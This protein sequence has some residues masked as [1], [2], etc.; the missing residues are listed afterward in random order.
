MFLVVFLEE[1]L[2]LLKAEIKVT[3]SLQIGR[4]IAENYIDSFYFIQGN[5]Q[6]GTRRKWKQLCKINS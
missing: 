4:E 6:I 1:C 2:C 3:K 5:G